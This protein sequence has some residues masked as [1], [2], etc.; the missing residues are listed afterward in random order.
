MTAV[1]VS[2][3]LKTETDSVSETL[4]FW[5]LYFQK[6]YTSNSE[7]FYF[8]ASICHSGEVFTKSLLSDG[9]EINM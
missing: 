6:M 9:T 5:Y 4:C 2:S 1:E 3:H 7:V 8:C